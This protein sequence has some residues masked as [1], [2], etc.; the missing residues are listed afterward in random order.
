MSS[1]WGSSS[2]FGG[3]SAFS[4]A[5]QQNSTGLF[6]SSANNTGF[7]QKPT[8][9]SNPGQNN[10]GGLFGNTS[11]GLF[12]QSNQATNSG[13][14]F[15]NSG[16]STANNS[17]NTAGGLFGSSNNTANTGSTG[18]FGSTANPSSNTGTSSNLLGG[19]ANSGGLFGNSATNNSTSGGLFGNSTTGAK[20]GGLFGASN[21]GA[22]TGSTAI[23]G[24]TGGLFGSK[25]TSG[26]LFGS[27]TSNSQSGGLFGKPAAPAASGG[28]FG[29]TPGNTQSGGM[30]GNTSTGTS[31][32]LFGNSSNNA[33]NKPALGILG[34]QNASTFNSG[35]AT[36]AANSNPY[37]SDTLASTIN[38][39]GFVMPQSIT[40]S[41]F[42]K[43]EPKSLKDRYSNGKAKSETPKS[44]L[45][46]KLA[47]TF[48]IFRTST[49]T[50][51]DSS[52]S[53]LKG[54]FSQENFVK[55]EPVIN[56][57]KYSVT[58]NRSKSL[59]FIR[60]LET[61]AADIKRLV[62][63]SKPLKFHLINAD[64]VFN[65]KKRRVLTL[66]LNA[67]QQH[68]LTDDEVS[69]IED[70]EALEKQERHVAQH[71]PIK[72]QE[73]DAS[74]NACDDSEENNDG[75]WTSPTIR[76]LSALSEHELTHV[77]NFIIGR[78]DVG[79]I[80]YN[81]P[82]DLSSLFSRC[83]DSGL[84]VGSELFGKIVKMEG[85]IVQVY[86]D[87]S[88]LITKPPIGFELN[89]PATITLRAPPKRNTSKQEHIRR[90]QNL[91]G[92]EFVTFDPLTDNWTFKV[93]H[94]SVWGLLDDSE[95]DQDDAEMSRL[96]E[97]KREQDKHEGEATAI[98]SRIYENEE[99]NQELKRQKIGGSTKGVPGGW[100]YASTSQNGGALGFK[101]K[102]VQDEINRQINIY[103]QDKS[104]DALAANASDITIESD[105][106]DVR[107]P[108]SL[109]LDGPIY[110]D[111]IRNYDYLKQI[112]SVMPPNTDFNDLVDE[113]AYEPDIEDEAVFD[114]FNRPQSLATSKDWLL[115]LELANGID[116]A[117]TPYLA[118]PRNQT[119]SIKAVNDILFS[120]FDGSSVDSNQISTPI[121]E[122]KKFTES[123][124]N[125]QMLSDLS[126]MPKLVQ[127]LLLKA[128]VEERKNKFPRS[129]L[130][131][132]LTFQEVASV[133]KSDASNDILEL[134]AILF[135]DVELSKVNKYKEVD[136]SD[137][138]LVLRLKHLTRRK[139]FASWLKNNRK[140]SLLKYPVTEGDSLAKIENFLCQG[141]LK[142]AIDVAIS[143]HNSHL[144]VLLTL[145]DS[146][147][148]VVKSIAL[149]QLEDWESSKTT[150]LI[151]V[152]TL[153]IY[154]IL[155]GKFD[156]VSEGC[157]FETSISLR[158][159]Y[160]S[161]SQ[162]LE[163]V[164]KAADNGA[165]TDE[166]AEVI[167]IFTSLKF[168][169]LSASVNAIQRAKLSDQTKWLIFSLLAGKYGDDQ[170]LANADIIS[171]SF[172][173]LLAA[174]G[175][176]KESL[177]IFSFISDDERVKSL[178]RATVSKEI[179]HIKSEHADEEQFL[180][181]VLGAPRSLV[182]EA[183]AIEKAKDKDF[184]GE[185]FAL[186][187]A[188]LWDQAHE[189]I[190]KHL[191]PAAVIDNDSELQSK[192]ASLTSRFPDQ[193]AIIPRWNQGA[194]LF[195][196]YFE[197]I[198]ATGQHEVVIADDLSFVLDNLALLSDYDSFTVKVAIKIMSKKIGDIALENKEKIIE[199]RKK[200][201]GLKLGENE[202]N[203][204]DNRL[205]ALGF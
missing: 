173:S 156:E 131:N 97:L 147:E 128:K 113:K 107:S 140:S 10:T 154:K 169:G 36:S 205:T 105:A 127:H 1:G 152:S 19:S 39:P 157:T 203:Y 52:I 22:S 125:S 96:R 32:G 177:F 88:Q 47:Q 23:G 95:D 188:R 180:V 134:A 138:E 27:S 65:A 45:F 116:S 51:N 89:V 162:K 76:D 41:L 40:G 46:T 118:I 78:K 66:A 24:T 17:S 48:N 11:G 98:Y 166:F 126:S 82:V 193:G 7:G 92:M 2:G 111:E 108:N 21:S 63:K 25:P 100:D 44:S 94:F 117:L 158:L 129:L 159:F 83:L 151:P 12:G 20:P 194:G 184:W 71:I 4:G 198:K 102:L 176:W 29:N 149:D 18:L 58:K 145:V 50:S 56:K 171:E 74:K 191:G 178:I 121:K 16:A 55:D 200:I 175:L 146:N 122:D 144:S 15:G 85:S 72:L 139:M 168:E 120:D 135:D 136:Y 172:G 179:K 115:Q 130:E 9:A 81:F 109:A 35:V 143:S 141:N 132:S 174:K 31:G 70:D 153:N 75:Y 196:K 5:T 26:G 192:L 38:Q 163:D 3:A 86:D 93:K 37:S 165:S 64:K 148:A 43:R 182:Y 6:G 101:Q 34:Q 106:E 181:K 150:E 33:F 73:T 133:L 90:L 68:A 69:D 104:V 161:P 201:M 87:E 59:A 79:Q 160:G 54:I 197:V 30:F 119:L 123:F 84:L 61:H 60:P 187:E 202:L 189:C 91:S 164:F 28:L 137:G 62:I 204:F 77:E 124:T 13:G 8:L 142:A 170:S 186:V 199:L 190:C 195:V 49:E 155:A 114:N 53:R 185:G 103:K 67:A 14:L 183:V 80:A 42:A 99:Y 110:P 57:S 167:Q 112:V